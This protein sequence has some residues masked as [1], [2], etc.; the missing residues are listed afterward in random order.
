MSSFP[1]SEERPY[2]YTRDYSPG[3]QSDEEEY[4]QS[5]RDRF[6]EDDTEPIYTPR[7][8]LNRQLKLHRYIPAARR[9][10]LEK[11]QTEEGQKQQPSVVVVH[12]PFD[13]PDG[14]P[15]ATVVIPVSIPVHVPPVPPVP[16]VS[17]PPPVG[18]QD[19][20]QGRQ[21]MEHGRGQG[22]YQDRNQGRNHD[23]DQGRHHDRDQGRGR[24]RGR[25]Q[26]RGQGQGR[27]SKDRKGQGPGPGLGR[28]SG[29]M[30]S[31]PLSLGKGPAWG[32]RRPT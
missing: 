11:E 8:Y 16:H 15:W 17:V 7:P 14:K 2:E 4:N 24:G 31:N 13:L 27:G 19:M 1:V 21:D 12:V 10:E 25:G 30:N 32:G 26:G 6:E 28:P 29:P 20:E 3:V 5:W 9:L 22:R 23:R 18:R